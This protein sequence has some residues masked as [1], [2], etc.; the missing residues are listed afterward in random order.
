MAGSRPGLGI[1]I[2]FIKC[3]QSRELWSHRG[4]PSLAGAALTA[5]IQGVYTAVIQGV[6]S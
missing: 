3:H 1:G 5:V 6:K 4:Q 2:I